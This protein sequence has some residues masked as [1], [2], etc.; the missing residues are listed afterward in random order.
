MITA[1]TNIPH[2]QFVA[3]VCREGTKK[4]QM[5]FSHLIDTIYSDGVTVWGSRH[6]YDMNTFYY[7]RDDAALAAEALTL[8]EKK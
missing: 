3:Q 4:P 1:E 8:V 6:I 7:R 5:C 2:E